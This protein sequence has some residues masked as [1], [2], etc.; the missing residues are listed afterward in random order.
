MLW[1]RL[2]IPF[3]LVAAACSGSGGVEDDAL[4]GSSTDPT[5]A[6]AVPATVP[7]DGLY[8]DPVVAGT[9]GDP[10]ITESSGLV[11]SARNPGLLWTHNDSGGGPVLYCLGPTGSS[12]GTWTV[13][14]AA[15]RDWED[16]A[17]G[18]GPEPGVPYLYVGDIGDNEGALAE[19]RVW[20]VP[21]PEVAADDGAATEP[22]E[23][24]RLRY[25][26]GP[27]DAEALLVN[28]ASGDLYVITKDRSAAGVYKAPAPLDPATAVTMER[29]AVLAV[30]RSNVDPR[31][32]FVTGA[33]IT[34]DAS[35]VILATYGAGYE[36]VLPPTAAAFD[37][38]WAAPLTPV[39]LGPRAQG[40]AVAYRSD[41][42]ALYATSEG[43]STPFHVT[44]RR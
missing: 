25:P 3:A 22:A 38:I 32:S 24:I 11:A 15:A 21:E 37:E 17:A 41:G 34:A 36:L 19:I 18:P 27:H 28:P 40:E 29:V 23:A 14:A 12:C 42:R 7:A 39:P 44:E 20:R 10:A 30:G 8:R 9:L 2:L 6:T 5:A 35:R 13:T 4:F 26:D 1:T 16:I 43:A 33:D 31:S